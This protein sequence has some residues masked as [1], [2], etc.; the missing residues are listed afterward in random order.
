MTIQEAI[1]RGSLPNIDPKK[2][3]NVCAKLGIPARDLSFLLQ[4]IN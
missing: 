2:M 4:M 3:I 1:S